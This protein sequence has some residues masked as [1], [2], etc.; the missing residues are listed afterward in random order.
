MHNFWSHLVA[1]AFDGLLILCFVSEA[2]FLRMDH[3]A[4]SNARCC[5]CTPAQHVLSLTSSVVV[6]ACVT[7]LSTPGE[8]VDMQLC[9]APSWLSLAAVGAPH[10]TLHLHLGSAEE[11]RSE[12]TGS[13]YR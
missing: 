9:L 11:G 2:A 13:S 1:H 5:S 12:A 3:D 8:V 6:G 10:V 7:I 4:L